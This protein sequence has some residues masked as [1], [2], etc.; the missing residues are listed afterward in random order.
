ML[1][2]THEVTVAWGGGN[3]GAQALVGRFKSD[4]C[5]LLAL[6]LEASYPVVLGLSSWSLG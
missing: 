6:L 5:L 1:R 4:L 3:A 2:S